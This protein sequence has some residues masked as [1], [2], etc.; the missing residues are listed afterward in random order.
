MKINMA[1]FAT[2]YDAGKDLKK[3]NHYQYLDSMSDKPD[4]TVTDTKR[5]LATYIHNNYHK[6]DES[7]MAR[8]IPKLLDT[9]DMKDLLMNFEFNNYKHD[10][11]DM[12]MNEFINFTL[13]MFKRY[14]RV[15]GYFMEDKD[16]IVHKSDSK[17]FDIPKNSVMF[18]NTLDKIDVDDVTGYL[19]KMVDNLNG[20]VVN[21]DVT[22]EFIEKKK[23]IYIQIWGK[24]YNDESDS[25]DVVGL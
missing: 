1:L 2:K 11:K 19:D 23:I 12:T 3:Y 21:Y 6:M 9:N 13:N 7:E 8:I 5:E 22:Y 20:G 10:S 17:K 25:D 18:L 14:Y 4:E 15:G 16:W 24:M